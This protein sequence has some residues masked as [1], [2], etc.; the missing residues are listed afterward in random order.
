MV[1][2]DAWYGAVSYPDDAAP[3]AVQITGDSEVLA[4]LS[5]YLSIAPKEA[6]A[7]LE[8]DCEF[9]LS[10]SEKE[11]PWDS[12]HLQQTGTVE[13]NDEGD[14]FRIG[15]NAPYAEKQHEDLTLHHPKPGTKAKYLEDP[16]M[17]IAPTIAEDIAD[18]LRG[19]FG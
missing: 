7:R 5:Y 12:T 17:R 15:Y 16:A 13:P 9:I 2:Q 19:I 18:H 14:G 3:A 4:N 10:E 8:V 1:G 11:V 6:L